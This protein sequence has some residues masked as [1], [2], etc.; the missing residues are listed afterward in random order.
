MIGLLDRLARPFLL[1]LDP[2][3]AHGLTIKV[4]KHLPL[5]PVPMT[6]SY[7]CSPPTRMRVSVIRGAA[8]PGRRPPLP[9]PCRRSTR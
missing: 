6:T 1:A 5:P 4:L 9:G 7:G 2:E 3:D 8:W